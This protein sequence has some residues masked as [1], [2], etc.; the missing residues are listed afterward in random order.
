MILGANY[1]LFTVF[2][3]PDHVSLHITTT[4]AL[5]FVSGTVHYFAELEH[6]R[7]FS[8]LEN[9]LTLRNTLVMVALYF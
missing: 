4:L 9:L 2:I 6:R 3:T 8:T 5:S 7:N 1:S